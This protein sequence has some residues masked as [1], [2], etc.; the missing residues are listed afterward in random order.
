M[1]VYRS[2]PVSRRPSRPQLYKLCFRR[3]SRKTR[4]RVP[5]ASGS[6]RIQRS[7]GGIADSLWEW[8]QTLREPHEFRQ[9]HVPFP[10]PL[11]IGRTAQETLNLR[12]TEVLAAP[13]VEPTHKATL[14][15]TSRVLEFC[16]DSCTAVCMGSGLRREGRLRPS[17]IRPWT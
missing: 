5:P 12:G 11:W 3:D 13:L 9:H 10:R 8:Q 17:G 2:S 7:H 6:G 4:R 14:R 16:R 1:N 15:Q